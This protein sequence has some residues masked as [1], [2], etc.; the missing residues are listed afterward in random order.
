MTFDAVAD[1]FGG[2]LGASDLPN[3]AFLFDTY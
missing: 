2:R 1:Q 3:L